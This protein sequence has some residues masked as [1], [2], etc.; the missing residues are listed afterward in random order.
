[1]FYRLRQKANRTWFRICCNGILN[2]EPIKAS[3]NGTIVISMVSQ[4]DIFMYLVAIKSFFIQLA[5]NA[6]IVILDDGTLTKN[7]YSLL[8]K[9]IE[10]LQII[11]IKDVKPSKYT[12]KGGTWERLLLI[13]DLVKDNYVIQLDS[14]TV[15]KD[16]IPEVNEH[17]SENK[18]F[19]I[20]TEF[21]QK[22]TPMK[23]ACE[24]AQFIKSDFVQVIAE[25]NF[26][27]L[28][29]YNSLQYTRCSASFTGFA[30]N[31]F[32]RDDIEKFSDEMRSLLGLKWF[33]WGS[34]QVTS[35]YIICNSPKA[36]ILP[37]PKYASYHAIQDIPYEESA[38][39]HFIGTSRFKNNLYIKMARKAI[40]KLK[41]KNAIHQ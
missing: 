21:N 27:N 28:K 24:K 3:N 37:Y 38:F 41:E 40:K 20:G 16:A 8:K 36:E 33:Q 30:K 39:L 5:N 15:T 2:T 14:D 25:R 10:G 1:M 12:P 18:S 22:I 7:N 11:N 31:S 13:A 26:C 34:E 32:L 6:R 19:A 9:N 29:D 17:I 4:N 23:I 35:N